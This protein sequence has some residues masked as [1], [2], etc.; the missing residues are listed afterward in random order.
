MK[1]TFVLL[2][3]FVNFLLFSQQK[4]INSPNSISAEKAFILQ[5]ETQKP[6]LFFF[7]TNWC[8]YCFTMKKNTFT[9]PKVMKLI[10][11]NFHFVSFDAES[12]ESVKVGNK[13]F[14]NN[15]GVHKLAITLASK[16]GY[17]SYPS[18]VIL[19][20][21]KRIDEQVDTFLSA[22]GLKKLLSAYLKKH[23]KKKRQ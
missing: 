6:I 16:N 17:M 4:E 13:T 11:D 14:E 2:L 3:C 20:H 18:L 23:Q 1:K 9:N 10:N 7:H 19:N 12:K 15:S 22:E 21:K 8:K 5:K